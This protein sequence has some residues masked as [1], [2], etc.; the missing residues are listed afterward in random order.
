MIPKHSYLLNYLLNP[1]RMPLKGLWDSSTRVTSWACLSWPPTSEQLCFFMS[2]Y[3]NGLQ[4]RNS[5][6]KKPWVKTQKSSQNLI[7]VTLFLFTCLSDLRKHQH[8]RAL[9][10]PAGQFL[11]FVILGCVCVCECVIHICGCVPQDT[12]IGQRTEGWVASLFPPYTG[13]G[14][15]FVPQML[16]P[17]SHPGTSPEWFL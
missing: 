9:L 4:H 2:P 12:N 7:K 11:K 15:E 17:L 1:Q 10:T 14:I 6:A 8:T 3:H 5:R 13:S 16:F